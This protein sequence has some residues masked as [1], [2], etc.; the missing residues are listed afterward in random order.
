MLAYLLSYLLMSC[1]SSGAYYS[2]TPLNMEIYFINLDAVL[3]KN[4]NESP[5]S[6][7]PFFFFLMHVDLQHALLLPPPKMEIHIVIVQKI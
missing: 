1:D 4:E 6:I 3:T 7:S 5:L 2:L